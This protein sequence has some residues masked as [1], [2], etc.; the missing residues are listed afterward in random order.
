M[1]IIFQTVIYYLI[2][3]TYFIKVLFFYVYVFVILSSI[4]NASI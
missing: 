2:P 1:L 4:Q 3:A